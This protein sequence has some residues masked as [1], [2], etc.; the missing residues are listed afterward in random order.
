MSRENLPRLLYGG[1]TDDGIVEIMRSRGDRL[2]PVGRGDPFYLLG[3]RLV[4][5][6]AM[7]ISIERPHY[8][9]IFA[10]RLGV[11]EENG[12]SHGANF[13]VSWEK[14]APVKYFFASAE[15]DLKE[16][17]YAVFK[18]ELERDAFVESFLEDYRSGRGLYIEPLAT[19]V[20]V[21]GEVYEELAEEK[22]LF[23]SVVKVVWQDFPLFGEGLPFVQVSRYS[24]G[25]DFSIRQDHYFFVIDRKG[26]VHIYHSSPDTVYQEGESLFD[27]VKYMF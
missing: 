11:I 26:E 1:Y 19:G 17:D 25:E 20:G 21:S 5:V 2:V 14:N 23:E 12:L 16:V 8:T 10:S 24:P 22:S 27:R 4:S 3:E 15:S 9:R 7:D 13:Y 6:L 18:G